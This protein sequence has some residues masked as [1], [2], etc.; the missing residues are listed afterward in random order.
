MPGTRCSV[1]L[2]SNS[3]QV[4]K[5][6]ELNISYHTFPKDK[7]L[8]NLWI[9]ACRRKDEWNPKTSTICSNHFLEDDFEVDLRS[10]LMN[11]KTKRKLK[12]QGNDHFLFTL[13]YFLTF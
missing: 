5:K 4:T 10:Q 2:Y 7:K 9:N 13:H 3:L 8:C 6:K 1:A 12:P 11:I